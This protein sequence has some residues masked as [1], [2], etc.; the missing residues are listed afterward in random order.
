LSAKLL[1]KNALLGAMASTMLYVY[2]MELRILYAQCVVA[3][4]FMV[5]NAWLVVKMY[6]PDAKK[7]LAREYMPRSVSRGRLL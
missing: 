6:R 5:G 2:Y 7:A 1:M 3:L 4:L